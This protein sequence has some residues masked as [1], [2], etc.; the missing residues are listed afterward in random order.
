MSV[1]VKCP[2]GKIRVYMKGADSIVRQ[3]ITLNPS[4]VETTDAFLLNYA[5]DGL[6]TLMIAFKE[7]TQTDYD[8]WEKEYIVNFSIDDRKPSIPLKKMRNSLLF[9]IKSKRIYTC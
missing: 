6:R 3:R 1:I 4:L 9:Q 2:Y 7:I 8:S 5:K